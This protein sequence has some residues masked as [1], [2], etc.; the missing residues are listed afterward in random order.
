MKEK[1]AFFLISILFRLLRPWQS[2]P[3][4]T[5]LRLGI[6]RWR[7]NQEGKNLSK[8]RLSLRDFLKRRGSGAPHVPSSK[9]L[10]KRGHK[11]AI[12][13]ENWG[14]TPYI[15]SE[16]PV[17]PSEDFEDDCAF[18]TKVLAKLSKSLKGLNRNR[19]ISLGLDM[20]RKYWLDFN[21]YWIFECRDLQPKPIITN[22]K[23]FCCCRVQ[24]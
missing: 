8:Q 5:F 23:V 2:M 16:P 18:M 17:P 1:I 15:F 14:P 19:Q 22:G 10:Q 9:I 7:K 24:V 6:D 13:H 4:E 12:K 20:S 3:V 21:R 11:N